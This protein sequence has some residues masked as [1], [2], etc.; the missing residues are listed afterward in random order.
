MEARSRTIK[1]TLVSPVIRWPTSPTLAQLLRRP[2][3]WRAVAVLWFLAGSALAAQRSDSAKSASPASA[4]A[5]PA[6]WTLRADAN[7]DSSDIRFS[8]MEPGYHLTLGPAV[9][10]Y[11][12]KDRVTGPFHTLARL[13]QTKKLEHAEGYGLFIGGRELDRS[14]Q[15]YTYFLIR[16]DGK[17][18]IKRRQGE[19]L[20]ELTDGWRDHPAIN[21]V[22]AK[23]ASANL[24]EIDAKRDP[25]IASFMVNGKEVHRIPASRVEFQGIVGL[26]VNH[27][28][29][30]HIEEF[31]IHE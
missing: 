16:S 30:I 17:F 21:Q 20:T 14:S 9:I 7:G 18:L 19:R 5:P 6:G 15:A 27:N 23:G 28:L 1:D 24:L 29:D 25:R 13:H 11:R 3:A 22:D 10:L 8:V 12:Q 4:G 2:Q 26:R 31:A